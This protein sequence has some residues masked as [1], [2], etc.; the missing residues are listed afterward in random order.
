MSRIE[1]AL[2]KALDLRESRTAEAGPEAAA[3]VASGARHVFVP[4]ATGLDRAL[5]DK[6]V[7]TI[8]DPGSP[9]AEQYR[10][11]RARI[12]LATKKDSL[13]TILVTSAGVGEG[14][15]MTAVNLAVAIA[16][17]LD[18]TVLL[19]DADLRRPAVSKYLGITPACGLGDCLSG[20]ATLKEAI[21]KTGI[22]RLAVL[23]AG[24]SPDN[25]AEALASDRMKDLVLEL[26]ARYMDR[27]VI[28]D[29]S[30][31]LVTADALSLG[32]FVDGVLLVAQADRTSEKDLS[33]AVA[34]MRGNNILG[35]V[36]NN[37]PERLAAA[38]HPYYHN[39]YRGHYSEKA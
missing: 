2:E 15:S 19:V 25:P 11:L 16:G 33:Q 3:Q 32:N 12:L 10:K 28:F 29:S 39:Y 27:Y 13:N 21:I 24:N 18:H 26:K 37:L 4:P 9:V 31:V 17:A 5:I 34:L 1:K 22:G 35:V 7:V 6:H 14:K 20:K 38:M 36:L 8:M 23:P 30:P